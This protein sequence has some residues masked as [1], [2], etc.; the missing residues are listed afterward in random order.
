[1]KI[2]WVLRAGDGNELL[3]DSLVSETDENLRLK[4]SSGK[5]KQRADGQSDLSRVKSIKV[6][7]IQSSCLLRLTNLC[8]KPRKTKRE[9]CL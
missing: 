9:K 8:W 5:P 4:E 1:M 2:R 3:G 6:H 7:Q